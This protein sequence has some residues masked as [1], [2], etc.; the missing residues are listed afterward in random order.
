MPSSFLSATKAWLESPFPA[1]YHRHEDVA[2][3]LPWSIVTLGTDM[4]RSVSRAA[5]R[6]TKDSPPK[7]PS[8]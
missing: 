1:A 3:L 2:F 7:R 5:R 6:M 8:A 4:P